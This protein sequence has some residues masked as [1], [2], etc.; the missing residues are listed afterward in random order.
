MVSGQV[1]TYVTV[2]Y[3]CR[4]GKASLREERF[5]R[6]GEKKEVCLAVRFG[7]L[8]VLAGD[9][10]ISFMVNVRFVINLRSSSSIST[11]PDYYSTGIYVF[12]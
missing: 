8:A 2:D 7:D 4:G 11:S 12:S 5:L 9:I 3:F 10:L 6:F 1:S